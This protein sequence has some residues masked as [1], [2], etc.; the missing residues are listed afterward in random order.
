MKYTQTEFDFVFHRPTCKHD[1]AQYLTHSVIPAGVVCAECEEL[2][3]QYIPESPEQLGYLSAEWA[4]LHGDERVVNV[5]PCKR[6]RR[7]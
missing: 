2:L 1:G 7:L 6:R 3:F 5:D 4:W